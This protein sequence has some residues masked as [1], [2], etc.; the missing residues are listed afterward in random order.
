MP[1]AAATPTKASEERVR[2]LN[3][4]SATV[5]AVAYAATVTAVRDTVVV[6]GARVPTVERARSEGTTAP[7]GSPPW[8][9]TAIPATRT[10]PHT[11]SGCERR[12]TS[13]P[14]ATASR[15]TVSASMTSACWWISG[16][17]PCPPSPPANGP[18]TTATKTAAASAASTGRGWAACQRH[19]D[20]NP[21]TGPTL[22]GVVDRDGERTVRPAAVTGDRAGGPHSAPQPGGRNGGQGERQ[23]TGRRRG[24]DGGD[25]RPPLGEEL[26][27]LDE[28]GIPREGPGRGE[29]GEPP[30][31][32]PRHP[33]GHG[34]QG[35]DAGD[36]APPQ[37]QPVAAAG[38]VRLG[39]SQPRLVDPQQRVQPEQHRTA[40]EPAHGVQRPCA[41]DR[42]CGGREDRDEEG[43]V[44][45]RQLGAGQRQDDLRRNRRKDALHRH[46]RGQSEPSGPAPDHLRDVEDAAGDAH[47][48]RTLEFA[49]TWPDRISKSMQSA[50]PVAPCRV[51]VPP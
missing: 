10:T 12:R 46:D 33:G 28:A 44:P 35:P 25:L 40:P 24:H 2:S 4:P 50:S 43:Q 23:Q 31:R 9:R 39:P 47:R 22:D 18:H 5:S 34:H 36:E 16:P 6:N 49:G 51:V 17:W 37:N 32:H 48:A 27:R 13:A 7:V 14:A 3:C 26:A 30:Q 42:A 11:M 45:A 38:E 1:T 19:N 15:T 8:A 21:R 20:A 29:R 41:D